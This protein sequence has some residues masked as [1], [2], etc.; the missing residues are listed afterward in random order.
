MVNMKKPTP[1]SDRLGLQKPGAEE[2][3]ERRYPT[4]P[5]V[6]EAGG[7]GAASSTF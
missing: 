3:P 5:V 4:S 1:R 6:A 2:P 7:L